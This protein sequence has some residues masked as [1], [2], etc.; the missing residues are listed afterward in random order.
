MLARWMIFG[1]NDDGTVNLDGAQEDVIVGLTPIQAES[2][3][4]ARD[5]FVNTVLHVLNGRH[6]GPLP[7]PKYLPSDRW[8]K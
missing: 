7:S 2:L 8:R 6:L 4:I 1:T 5:I 3:R